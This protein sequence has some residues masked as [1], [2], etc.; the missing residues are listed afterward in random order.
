MQRG[1]T[2][3]K[4]VWFSTDYEAPSTVRFSTTY[5]NYIRYGKVSHCSEYEEKWQNTYYVEKCN[6]II[7][8]DKA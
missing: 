7:N 6:C 3:T 2:G 1:V 8:H 5:Y 4:T